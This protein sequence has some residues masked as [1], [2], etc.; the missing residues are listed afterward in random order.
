MAKR[1]PRLIT[2]PA[3]ATG[4][5]LDLA[6]ESKSDS[7]ERFYRSRVPK[8]HPGPNRFHGQKNGPSGDAGFARRDRACQGAAA[9]G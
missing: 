3:T 1:D 4:C 8:C 2:A 9:V 5:R 7:L 6:P